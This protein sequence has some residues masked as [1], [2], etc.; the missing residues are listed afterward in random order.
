MTVAVICF[1]IFVISV[2]TLILTDAFRNIRRDLCCNI[3]LVLIGVSYA[4]IMCS[5]IWFIASANT[6]Q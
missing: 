2:S 3:F 4:G 5:I 6:N 1:V